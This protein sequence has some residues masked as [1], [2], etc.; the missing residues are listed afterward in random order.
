MEPWAELES[1][2]PHAPRRRWP[3]VAGAVAVIVATAVV[4]SAATAFVLR[5]EG[6]SGDASD[7]PTALES[8]EDTCVSGRPLGALDLGDDGRSMS[9]SRAGAD[10]DPGLDIDDVACILTEL[11][12]PD[13]VVARIDSTRALDGTRD[14][15]WGDFYATWTYHPDDGL[16]MVIE[17]RRAS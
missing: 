13:A 14:A 12:V 7:G 11:E 5:E 8:A 16:N 10:E 17:E 4:S 6:D 15:E 9:I 2:P 1:P 3:L